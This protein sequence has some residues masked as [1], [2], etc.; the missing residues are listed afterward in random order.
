FY[1][2]TIEEVKGFKKSIE[3]INRLAHELFKEGKNSRINFK[4][5]I[6][7]LIN[8]IKSEISRNSDI[9]AEKEKEL[10]NSLI[11]RFDNLQKLDIEGNVDELKGA[12][13]YYL[14]Q[15]NKQGDPAKWIVRNFEQIDGDVLRSSA[16]RYGK[17]TDKVYHFAGLSEKYMQVKL[18]DQLTWPLD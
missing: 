15:K 10:L 18:K 1:S 5:H 11:D 3:Y 12:I 16:S 6:E 9:I 14:K 8:K 7:E 13:F 17:Y 4:E 2:T